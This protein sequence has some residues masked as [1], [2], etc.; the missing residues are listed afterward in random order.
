[1]TECLHGHGRILTYDCAPYQWVEQCTQ[2]RRL[3]VVTTDNRVLEIPL[4]TAFPTGDA[5]G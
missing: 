2:C 3:A 5:G 4:P 1:M